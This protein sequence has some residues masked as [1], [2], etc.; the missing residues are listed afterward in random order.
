MIFGAAAITSVIGAAHASVSVMPVFR[1]M[2]TH[3]RDIATVIFIAVALVV[4]L[5]SGTAPAALLVFAGGLN[6][7]ILPV[8]LTI[9]TYIGF[10]RADLMGGC[11]DSRVLLAPSGLV[12]TLT[13]T[14]GITSV[15]P[16]FAFPGT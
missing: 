16:I 9:F 3:A 13:W 1:P 8:G 11:R 14:M 10:A 15:S 7:L 4:Y 5:L 2:G 6:G 12:C